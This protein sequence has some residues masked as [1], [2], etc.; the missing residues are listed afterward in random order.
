ML[1]GVFF[2]FIVID[3]KHGFFSI[4][5]LNIYFFWIYPFKSIQKIRFLSA[6]TVDIYFSLSKAKLYRE[7]Q[8]L[9]VELIQQE[10]RALLNKHFNR[11]CAC[12]YFCTVNGWGC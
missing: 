9:I 7:G 12:L 2:R 1:L 10:S 6:N 11:F 8:V 5:L 4:I 3:E